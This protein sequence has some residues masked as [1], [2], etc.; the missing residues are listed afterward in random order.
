MKSPLSCLTLITLITFSFLACTKNS[1]TNNGNSSLIKTWAI[2]MSMRNELT[3]SA[4][5][6]DK[7]YCDT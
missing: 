3:A 5:R 1:Y 6:E 7:W 2:N 4:G